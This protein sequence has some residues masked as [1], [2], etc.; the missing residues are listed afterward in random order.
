MTVDEELK[1][2]ARQ[3]RNLLL[4][5]RLKEALEQIQIQMSG[6][7]DIEV[8]SRYEDIDRAYHYMLQYYS[9]GSPDEHRTEVYNQL[10]VICLHLRYR[11]SR[12]HAR[13]AV[14][15]CMDQRSVELE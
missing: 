11:N 4:Q 6:V 10:V 12:A 3:I 1:Q 15:P 5:A 13:S 2:R 7:S 14:R 9:Q 8:L